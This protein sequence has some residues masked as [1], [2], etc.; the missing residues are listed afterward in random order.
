MTWPFQY[1]FSANFRDSS[2]HSRLPIQVEVLKVVQID[3]DE[4]WSFRSS[5]VSRV[6]EEK[7]P[8]SESFAAHNGLQIHCVILQVPE[9]PMCCL[10]WP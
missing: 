4:G 1:H 10:K 6:P 2:F 5:T 7:M 9:Y 3:S 8:A